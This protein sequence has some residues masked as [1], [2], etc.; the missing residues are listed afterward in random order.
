MTR[1]EKEKKKIRLKNSFLLNA[2][3]PNLTSSPNL[4]SNQSSKQS[5]HAR[6][7]ERKERKEGT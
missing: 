5:E 7:K 1:K 6:E 2:N 4:P 3:K